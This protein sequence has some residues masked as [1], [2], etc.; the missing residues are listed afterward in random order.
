MIK[1]I[2]ADLDGQKIEV[3]KLPIGEYA[4]LLKAIKKLPSHFKNID[5][6]DVST[7]IDKLP[8]II[9]DSLPDLLAVISIATKM[10]VEEVEQLGLDDISKLIIAIYKVNNYAEVYQLIKKGLAHPS[11]K[12][13]KQ[14]NQKTN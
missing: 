3:K 9:G 10:P 7:I 11:I 2:I 4:E 5:D 1:T 8:E 6:L 12:Q 14:E 13:L